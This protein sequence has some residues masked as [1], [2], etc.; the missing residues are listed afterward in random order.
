MP[1]LIEHYLMQ[2]IYTDYCAST[3]PV[4]VMLIARVNFIMGDKFLLPA[5][6]E[7]ERE[8]NHF[9]RGYFCFLESGEKIYIKSLRPFHVNDW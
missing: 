5:Q 6:R 8:Y 3:S 7:R 4:T 9:Y 2:Q 1:R